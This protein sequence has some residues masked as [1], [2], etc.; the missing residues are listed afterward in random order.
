MSTDGP[1]AF[2]AIGVS[3]L[4]IVQSSSTEIGGLS[5]VTQISQTWQPE[6]AFGLTLSAT[7]AL[8][9]TYGQVSQ[10]SLTLGGSSESEYVAGIKT[11]TYE[12]SVPLEIAG[13]S[14]T[15]LVVVANSQ[16]VLELAATSQII[17]N[18]LEVSSVE[19]E[20]GGSSEVSFAQ[21][22]SSTAALEISGSSEYINVYAPDSTAALE[23]SSSV[24]PVQTVDAVSSGELILEGSTDTGQLKDVTVISSGDLEI[25][26]ET[27]FNRTLG[28]TS[29]GQLRING[30]STVVVQRPT[31]T[32]VAS[33]GS[34]V[35]SSTTE[36]S[37]L[38]ATI[39][40]VGELEIGITNAYQFNVT[41]LEK[42]HSGHRGLKDQAQ[43]R[44]I[45]FISQVRIAKPK[46]QSEV[47]FYPA[48]PAQAETPKPAPRPQ[49]PF[50]KFL[51]QY[52]NRLTYRYDSSTATVQFGIQ[53][54]VEVDNFGVRNQQ[55]QQDDA[56]LL[57]FDDEHM[58]LD[59]VRTQQVI[60]QFHDEKAE[61]LRRL[62]EDRDLLGITD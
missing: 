32:Q 55:I 60:Q 4:E 2:S 6:S 50:G 15:N 19:L 41:P 36:L 45:A 12:V 17:F 20:I 37:G 43:S 46:V 38:L 7:G 27:I 62:Q 25:S 11:F 8:S 39:E 24:V 42:V 21:E 40:G 9:L 35:I 33:S 31:I 48:P 13:T 23:I 1:I 52:G 18:D 29:T 57:G 34:L 56:W 28:F 53:S 49:G 30:S 61:H 44:Q 54:T 51:D 16:G 26:S 47:G 58:M 59:S 22:R 3:N 10:G 5:A 14:T